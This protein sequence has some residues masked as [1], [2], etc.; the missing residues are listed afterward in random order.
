MI[1]FQVDNLVFAGIA[2]LNTAYPLDDEDTS[3]VLN[4]KQ[5]N[6]CVVTEQH[7]SR[8]ITVTKLK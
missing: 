5:G 1:K 4:L 6:T 7:S 3:R 8:T 2:K